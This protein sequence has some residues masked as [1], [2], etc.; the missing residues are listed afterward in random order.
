MCAFIAMRNRIQ[1]DNLTA[2]SLIC[3]S[4]ATPYRH[5]PM[6]GLLSEMSFPTAPY[7]ATVPLKK[8]W[9]PEIGKQCFVQ[10]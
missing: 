4:L 9:Q 10:H 8:W 2:K 1:P 3:C 6:T 7:A 5:G